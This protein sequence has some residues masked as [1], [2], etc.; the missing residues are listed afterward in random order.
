MQHIT[1]TQ[2]FEIGYLHLISNLKYQLCIEKAWSVALQSVALQF[3][4]QLSH[5]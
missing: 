1:P 4:R 2:K 3:V 5:A